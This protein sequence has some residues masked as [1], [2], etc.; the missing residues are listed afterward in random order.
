MTDPDV[1]MNLGNAYKKIGEGG[2]AQSAYESALTLNPNY[3]AASYRIGKIYQTQGVNQIEI[4]MKYFNDAIAKDATYAP[5]YENLYQ[6]L[7]TTNVGQSA[8]Y[9]EK[10][11]TNTDDDP[12]NCYYRASMKS[13]FPIVIEKIIWL[14]LVS[15]FVE[16]NRPAAIELFSC[17]KRVA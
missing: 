17:P 11:L 2:P 1:Y 4:T 13:L 14:N 16:S 7:Y 15:P 3:A 8:E 5:V 12:K 9:L 6:Y 10:Y